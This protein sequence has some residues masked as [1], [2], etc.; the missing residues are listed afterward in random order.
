MW[1][2]LCRGTFWKQMQILLPF[3]NGFKHV[4]TILHIPR[5]FILRG[6]KSIKNP[7]HLLILASMAPGI[8]K[9]QAM[10]I[11]MCP[12]DGCRNVMRLTLGKANPRSKGQIPVYE[13]HPHRDWILSGSTGKTSLTPV[14]NR[15]SCIMN[16]RVLIV[17]TVCKIKLFLHTITSMV[18]TSS[19]WSGA[20]LTASP[21][22]GSLH[23]ILWSHSWIGF[24]GKCTI[25]QQYFASI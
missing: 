19:Q 8:C 12:V 24:V 2:K 1:K 6:I 3:P 22:P 11:I 18:C 14:G 7:E 4:A 9:S 5:P 21:S 23:A 25:C 13:P 20:Q 10:S 17:L 15:G 16:T